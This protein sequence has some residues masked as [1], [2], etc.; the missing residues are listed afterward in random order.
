MKKNKPKYVKIKWRDHFSDSSWK[1]K[2]EIKKWATSS[3]LC[4]SRGEITYE[5]DKVIVLS[6]SFDG[7]ESWGEN[8]C[9]LKVN[10]DS[11]K[12]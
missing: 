10:I 11:E 4:I 5:D 3:T 1:T 2:N 6:A 12:R 9:I 8:I 7:D